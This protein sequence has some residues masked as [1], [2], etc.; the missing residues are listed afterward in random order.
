[1]NHIHFSRPWAISDII[2]VSQNCTDP[3]ALIPA[4]IYEIF[5]GKVRK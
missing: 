5:L 1:M 3:N 2:R 4:L